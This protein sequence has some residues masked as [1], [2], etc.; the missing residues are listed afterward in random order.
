MSKFL[1][2]AVLAIISIFVFYKFYM[3]KFATEYNANA[4]FVDVRSAE[5]FAGGSA[6]NA[7]NIPLGTIASNLDKFAGQE[8]VVV[9]CRSGNRSG[10]AKAILEKNGI[11]NVLNGGPWQNVAKHVGK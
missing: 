9:F 5:E 6:P 10:Q 11:R 8:Q 1:V 3:G 2:I 7:I 4:L